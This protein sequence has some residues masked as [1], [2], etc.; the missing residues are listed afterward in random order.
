MMMVIIM[1]LLLMAVDTMQV[2]VDPHD[3][4]KGMTDKPDSDVDNNDQ[5]P[6]DPAYGECGSRGLR[7]GHGP[8]RPQGPMGPVV[9]VF[10][11]VNVKC[12]ILLAKDDEDAESHL[13][14]SNDW[15]NSEDVKCSRFCFSLS[16]GTHLLYES[17]TPVSNDWNTLQRLFCRQFSKVRH[18]KR[19][20]SFQSDEA[21]D[22]IDS[23]TLHLKTVCP[24]AR[25]Q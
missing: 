12:L 9:S 10:M 5:V 23:L 22:T 13:L 15:T 25:V 14:H 20:R 11:N 4:N 17:I 1:R 16:S 8:V 7:G 21:T 18:T 3:N 19:W 24:N 2:Q 6:G